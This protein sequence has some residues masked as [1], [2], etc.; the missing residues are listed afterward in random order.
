M[1][2]QMTD[3]AAAEEEQSLREQQVTDGAG[4]EEDQNLMEQQMSDRTAE[5]SPRLR[6]Q[7]MPDEADGRGKQKDWEAA[8]A[9]TGQ[10]N[11][12]AHEDR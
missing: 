9:S 11:E 1:E 5:A 12:A 7:K 10:Q 8:A 4:A 6:D 3:G 2:Q